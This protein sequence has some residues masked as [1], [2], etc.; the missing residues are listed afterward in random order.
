MWWVWAITQYIFYLLFIFELCTVWK[1]KPAAV[2]LWLLSHFLPKQIYLKCNSGWVA[3]WLGP[4]PVRWFF[5]KTSLSLKWYICGTGTGFLNHLTL[6]ASW[7]VLGAL[8][9]N[10]SKRESW[11]PLC[12][13]KHAGIW[14]ACRLSS[15]QNELHYIW[16][17]MWHWYL[18]LNDKIMDLETVDSDSVEA[19]HV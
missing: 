10:S 12:L 5:L 4:D 2:P 7:E 14:R 19:R 17:V 11:Q 8:R 3:C 9:G 18:C 6:C 16:W 15:C 13:D 1:E